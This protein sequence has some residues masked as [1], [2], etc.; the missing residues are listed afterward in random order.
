MMTAFYCGT[1]CDDIANCGSF[2]GVSGGK[3][4]GRSFSRQSPK[5]CKLILSIVN[6]VIEDSL[7]DEIVA[8]IALINCQRQWQKMR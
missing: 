2:L 8:T 7:K 1:G 3:S 6:G 4:W 5:M